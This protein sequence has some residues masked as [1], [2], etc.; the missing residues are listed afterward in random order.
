MTRSRFRQFRAKL[1][2]EIQQSKV[3]PESIEQRI[4]SELDKRLDL[5]LDEIVSSPKLRLK[6][7]P[8]ELDA[9]L[10]DL[11]NSL[12]QGPGGEAI[13]ST[14]G[15]EYVKKQN[16]RT[17]KKQ[18]NISPKILKNPKPVFA[19]DSDFLEDWA[20]ENAFAPEDWVKTTLRRNFPGS[21]D[22]FAGDVS[23]SELDSTNG[24]TNG[25]SK[26]DGSH[27]SKISANPSSSQSKT[28][29]DALMPYSCRYRDVHEDSSLGF[30]AGR[31]ILGRPSLVHTAILRPMP[32]HLKIKH[33]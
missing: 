6:L 7:S 31:R 15:G 16:L 3:F 27:E 1:S 22:K 5:D 10:L 29:L 30:N 23:P 13:R 24:G 32:S 19:P 25:S 14:F 18:Q 17:Q 11:Y 4:V 28:R 2:E 20:N 12:S 26:N 33:R 9:Q 21:Y 8:A